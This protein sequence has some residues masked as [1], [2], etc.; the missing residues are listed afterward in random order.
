MT[1]NVTALFG[2]P[3]FEVLSTEMVDGEWHVGIETPRDL[4]GC[5]ECG[6]VARVKDRRTVT[7]RDLPAAGVP[8]GDPVAET[9]LRV[10]IRVVPQ[11]DMDR[12]APGDR[13]PGSPDGPGQAVGVRAG[14]PA[15]PGR[16]ARRRGPR[17]GLE[18][19]HVSGQAPRETAGRRPATTRRGVRGRGRRDRVPAVLQHPPHAVRDRHRR[20][21]PRPAR[22]PA[23]RRRGPLRH[24]ARRVARRPGRAVPGADRDRL[25]RSVPRLRHRARRAAPEGGPGAGRLPRRETGPD[26]RR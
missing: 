4:V 10:P 8:V 19:D 18:H 1:Q 12:A 17:G 11:Q 22:A 23:G 2:M 15:R 7:V 13:V 24:R 21:H 26:L 6:A 16:G 5:G 9:D 20:P 3:G 25:A 14:R